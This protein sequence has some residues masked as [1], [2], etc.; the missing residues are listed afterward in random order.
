MYED[1]RNIKI[2]L[3]FCL[4]ASDEDNRDKR[5]NEDEAIFKR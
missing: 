5:C 3:N 2:I 4:K 1:I